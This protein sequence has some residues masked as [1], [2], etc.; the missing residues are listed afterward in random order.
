MRRS[1][2]IAFTETEKLSGTNDGATTTQRR[3]H[4]GMTTANA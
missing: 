3:N 4:S 2:I 1:Q